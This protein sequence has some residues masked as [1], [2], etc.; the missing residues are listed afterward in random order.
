MAGWTACNWAARKVLK[1]VETKAGLRDGN[2][3][4]RKVLPLVGN[5]AHRKVART[6]DRTAALLVELSEILTAVH[7]VVHWASPRVVQS[8]YRW[9]AH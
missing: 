4:A 5:L 3:V 1:K 9:A 7:W 6:V 2:S 8:V